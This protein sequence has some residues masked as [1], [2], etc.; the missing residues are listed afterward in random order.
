[1]LAQQRHQLILDA[2]L[3]EGGVRTIDLAQ[4]CGV[5]EETVRR[6]F[7]KLEGAGHLLRVHGGA[8]PVEGPRRD[9]PFEEREEL[10]RE[11][12]QKIAREALTRIQPGNTI[13]LDASSTALHL[14]RLLPEMPLTLLTNSW[15]I[16]DALREHPQEIKTILT[17]GIFKTSSRSLTGPLVDLALERFRINHA[18]ISCRGVDPA[19]GFCEANEETARIKEHMISL[20]DHT[21]IL[22]DHSKIGLR[23][24]FFFAHPTAVNELITDTTAPA[25]ALETLRAKGLT[26]T[27]VA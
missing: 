18:F 11:E 20:A 19:R 24:S 25:S 8:V 1:M 26:V 17:G 7:E 3:S 23:S 12:K 27:V 22:A 13:L 21:T 6:D 14:A 15:T 5:S 4:R 2:L 10:Q 9:M 16:L